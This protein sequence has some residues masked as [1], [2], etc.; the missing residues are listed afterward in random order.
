MKS[1][2]VI[3]P[4]DIQ[5][6]EEDIPVIGNCKSV[7]V[8]VKAAGICGSDLSIAS[9]TSPVATYPRVIGH[10]FAGEI[11]EAGSGVTR[12]QAGDHV[13]VNPVV[14]CG[15]CRPC[16]KGRSN[17]CASLSVMG[18][19][20]DGGFREYAEVPEDN[21]Y[22][23]SGDIPWTSAA[24]IEP[25][26]IAAQ[27]VSRGGVEAEDT[28]LVLGC[29][30]AG[31]TILQVVKMLGAKCVVCDITH[32][33]L[34]RAEEFG[35]DAA[36]D[37]KGYDLVERI[38]EITAGTGVDI[39]IDAAGAGITFE[40]AVQCVRPAGVVVSMGF[41][42]RPSKIRELDITKNELD[43]RGSRLNNNKFPQAIEWFES[44]K[45][46]AGKIITDSFHFTDIGKAFDKIKNYPESTLKV[47][48]TFN[49]GS[50]S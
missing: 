11:V 25:Y 38:M 7:L 46:N 14:S 13:A 17:V 6:V 41:S 28:V 44:A 23:I 50:I 48:L 21:V 34:K 39:A 36:I 22:R 35:A 9:G 26:T 2:K 32:G 15:E 45:L 37:S 1:I 4:G 5:V 19:H 10:E 3:K 29:G 31:L 33:R 12:V 20:R 30:A 43:I 49:E 47:I 16:K 40:Q 42:D 18:V 27:V 24:I 8:K